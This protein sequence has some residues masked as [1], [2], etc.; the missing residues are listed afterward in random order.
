VTEVTL[1][2]SETLTN[3]TINGDNNTLSNLDIGNEVDWPVATDVTDRTAF[4]SG[5]KLLIHEAGVGLRKIDYDDLPGASGAL[6]ATNGA[7]NRVAVFSSS[8]NVN[9]DA[10]FIWLDQ[11]LTI[12]GNT[13]VSYL[14]LTNGIVANGS[15]GTADQVLTANSTG[16]TFWGQI[17]NTVSNIDGGN[18]EG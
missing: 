7:A 18:A 11:R 1:A 9:G 12:T 17:N 13:S 8:D 4:A 15:L 14:E 10:N 2:G 5:D 3:K 16:G 6:T